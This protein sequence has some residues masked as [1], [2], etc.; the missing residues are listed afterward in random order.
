M[1]DFNKEDI[2]GQ[3]N[4]TIFV[5]ILPLIT[6]IYDMSIRDWFTCNRVNYS[7]MRLSNKRTAPKQNKQTP[8]MLHVVIEVNVKVGNS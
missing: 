4:N 5:G 6:T 2:L 8:K 3:N 1:T 7:N